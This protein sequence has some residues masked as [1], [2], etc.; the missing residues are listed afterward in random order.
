MINS[1]VL[2]VGRFWAELGDYEFFFIMALYIYN[3]YLTGPT[4][5]LKMG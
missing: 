1:M 3:E 2:M 4:S 5:V